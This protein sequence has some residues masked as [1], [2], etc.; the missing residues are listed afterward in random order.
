[1]TK[2]QTT[3]NRGSFVIFSDFMLRISDLSYASAQRAYVNP[4]KEKQRQNSGT[5]GVS[6]LRKSYLT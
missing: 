1:M 6:A 5:H 4:D 3:K 2:I